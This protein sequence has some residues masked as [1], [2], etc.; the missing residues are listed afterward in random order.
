[1]AG[2]GVASADDFDDI[3]EGADAEALI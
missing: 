1:F 2:G 3:S